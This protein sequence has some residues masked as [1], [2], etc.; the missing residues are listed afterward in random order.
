[1]QNRSVNKRVLNFNTNQGNRDHENLF[2]EGTFN[3]N[4]EDP[5]LNISL[6]PSHTYD[7]TDGYMRSEHVPKDHS[8]RGRKQPT[9]GR[10]P[11]GKQEIQPISSNN[12]MNT[13]VYD[14]ES[15]MVSHNYVEN[16]ENHQRLKLE[17]F[18]NKNAEAKFKKNL[19]FRGKL[20]NKSN[21]ER[22]TPSRINH[23]YWDK[24]AQ[25]EVQEVN[26]GTR[27][28]TTG[29]E[30]YN[31]YLNNP[32]GQHESSADTDDNLVNKFMADTKPSFEFEQIKINKNEMRSSSISSSK[33]SL[34]SESTS[35]NELVGWSYQWT[36]DGK[37]CNMSKDFEWQ[38]LFCSRYVNERVETELAEFKEEIEKKFKKAKSKNYTF[39]RKS[40]KKLTPAHKSWYV[41]NKILQK[42][43]NEAILLSN[44]FILNNNIETKEKRESN[45]GVAM[46]Q[47]FDDENKHQLSKS[48]PRTTN[49]SKFRKSKHKR[50][51][52]LFKF[53]KGDNSSKRVKIMMKANSNWSV[54]SQ[55]S[56]IEQIKPQAKLIG[57]A[58]TEAKRY[59]TVDQRKY[60]SKYYLNL[61]FIFYYR[62]I[63]EF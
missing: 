28:P 23:E 27:I 14:P 47:T 55:P 61:N 35:S 29:T 60:Q 34:H 49:N 12:N 37:L 11:R 17:D 46:M 56:I 2:L 53:S 26:D 38:Q 6:E 43:E 15:I 21:R 7:H 57:K 20:P 5:L 39:P 18:S 62:Y 8:G 3:S 42:E 41:Y 48:L 51:A 24:Y 22:S 45:R 1:M 9:K 40:E 30:N 19:Q 44:N 33:I 50:Q 10:K 16:N 32:T 36:R 31:N 58:T 4:E 63:Y 54:D 13:S 25:P 59:K 52:T